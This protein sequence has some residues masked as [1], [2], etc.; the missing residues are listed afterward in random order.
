MEKIINIS[1]NSNNFS[2]NLS[3]S[4][5]IIFFER[6]GIEVN[7]TTIQNY[8]RVGILPPLDKKR[9]Y[10]FKHIILLY[11][12]NYLKESYSLTEIKEFTEYIRNMDYE[13]VLEYN[14]HLIEDFNEIINNDKI[15]IDKN[16][17]E[18]KILFILVIT[19]LKKVSKL[20]NV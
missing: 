2:N 3:I 20:E 4:K 16:I 5:V 19:Y 10:N 6:N 1:E 13:K 9:Y 8:V 18:N 11:L 14:K 15:E 7:K 17:R 12:T